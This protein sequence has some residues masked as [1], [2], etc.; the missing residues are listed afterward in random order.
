MKITKQVLKK[1]IK[2]ELGAI[3]ELDPVAGRKEVCDISDA[4]S[5]LNGV[6]WSILDMVYS[7][8]PKLQKYKDFMGNENERPS[9]MAP[10]PDV[11]TALERAGREGMLKAKDCDALKRWA[12][13]ARR[14]VQV[15]DQMLSQYDRS[16]AA[17]DD[18]D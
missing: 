10:G 18:D 7:D 2:E 12:R 8:H 5:A 15:L 4:M 16:G 3:Q 13:D 9:T 6:G 14:A 1:L 11:W 17:D